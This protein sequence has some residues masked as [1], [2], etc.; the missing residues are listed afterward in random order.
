MNAGGIALQETGNDPGCGGGGENAR[1][2]I[3]GPT[4]STGA[5][6]A[7]PSPP[8]APSPAT[9]RPAV[10]PGAPP[11]AV[12]PPARAAPLPAPVVAVDT[13]AASTP[14][15]GD[16]ASARALHALASASAIAAADCQRTP[17]TI[18]RNVG[19][20]PIATSTAAGDRREP[21][22]GLR[23]SSRTP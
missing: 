21:G 10:P 22:N 5:Q 7:P 11:L 4:W 19:M 9:A 3:A 16:G 15:W 13:E 20:R 14:A 18:Q 2:V 1:A 6:S 23:P 17:R 8:A 12:A